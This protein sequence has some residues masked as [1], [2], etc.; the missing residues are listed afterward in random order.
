MNGMWRHSFGSRWFSLKARLKHSVTNKAFPFWY[1]DTSRSLPIALDTFHCSYLIHS[2]RNRSLTLIVMSLKLLWYFGVS[3]RSC[4]IQLRP[5]YQQW[6]EPDC[7]WNWYEISWW[8]NDV[9][10]SIS[11]LFSNLNHS[12]SM[13]VSF[14]DC[15]YSVHVTVG[16]S[17][18]NRKVTSTEKWPQPLFRVC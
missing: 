17:G 15:H 13:Q 12:S 16:K 1:F 3:S 18:L 10:S 11:N 6:Q 14:S 2:F 4:D 5:K 7:H 8:I 9:V